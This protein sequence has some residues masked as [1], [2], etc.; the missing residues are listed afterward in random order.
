MKYCHNCEWAVHETDGYTA[1]ERK[2]QALEH[3]IETGHTVDSSDS[4]IRP[5]VPTVC[6]EILL[7]ELLEPTTF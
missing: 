4:A 1:Q 2:E 6:E 3:H 7:E 5:Q